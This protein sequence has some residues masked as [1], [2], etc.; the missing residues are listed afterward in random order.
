MTEYGV[1]TRCGLTV[2]AVQTT[3]PSCGAETTPEEDS[4]LIEEWH[5]KKEGVCIECG[6]S[7]RVRRLVKAKNYNGRTKIPE[8]RCYDCSFKKL[9]EIRARGVPV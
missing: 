4:S 6:K 3:C 1:C 8:F 2:F 7:G 9:D 5:E